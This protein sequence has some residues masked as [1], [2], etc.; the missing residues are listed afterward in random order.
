MSR[1]FESHAGTPNPSGNVAF[2]DLLA[3]DAQRRALLVGTSAATVAA[4]AGLPA[5]SAPA[6]AGGPPP[7][8]QGVAA[9]G[10]EAVSVAPG[11]DTQVTRA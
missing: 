7:G 1:F 4:I 9:S 6:G 8:F 5:C 2:S 11:A 3:H 10:A